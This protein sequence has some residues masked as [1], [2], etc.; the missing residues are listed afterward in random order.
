M[1]A[2]ANS[3]A[4]PSTNTTIPSMP[5]R[6]HILI[7]FTC[8][9]AV[10]FIVVRWATLEPSYQ[11]HSLTQW[12][13][14][15]QLSLTTKHA[16]DGERNAERKE[17][18]QAL[19][20]I[21]KKAIPHLMRLLEREEPA[22]R[23]D[24]RRIAEPVADKLG[25]ETQDTPELLAEVLADALVG[26]GPDAEVVIPRLSAIIQKT[27]SESIAGK[28]AHVLAGFG[29]K[30]VLPLLFGIT[31]RMGHFRAAC[32]FAAGNLK[33][34]AAPLVPSLIEC[35]KDPD[36]SVRY[37]AAS[38]LGALRLRPDVVVPALVEGLEQKARKDRWQA[39]L[40]L[41]RFGPEARAAAGALQRVLSDPDATLRRYAT[42]ALRKIAPEYLTN[43]PPATDTPPP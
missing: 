23:R 30:A 5:P 41:G 43:A 27:A 4:M 7:L 39:I 31:N 2:C 25:I 13:E 17:F 9:L 8:V 10:G 33:T 3:L 40:S 14:S 20:H 16:N 21:G 24:L 18:A 35:L 12:L 42:N 37:W 19:N 15:H 22:W 38:T 29:E 1:F 32:I 11:G 36:P 28:A 26:I 6:R 34:N